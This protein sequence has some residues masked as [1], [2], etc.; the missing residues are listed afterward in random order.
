MFFSF[1][2]MGE[3]YMKLL[4]GT[5]VRWQCFYIKKIVFLALEVETA[6][7]SGFGSAL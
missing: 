6:L 1:R 5:R 7:K 4:W 3:F 2:Q